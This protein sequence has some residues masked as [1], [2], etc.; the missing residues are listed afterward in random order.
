MTATFRNAAGS[1]A[2]PTTIVF[3]IRTPDGVIASYTYGVGGTVVKSSTGVYYVDTTASQSGT[4]RYRFIGTG[5]VITAAE[6]SFDVPFS[7]LA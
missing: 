2:D 5:A 1:V 3:K 4:T 7:Y 6:S